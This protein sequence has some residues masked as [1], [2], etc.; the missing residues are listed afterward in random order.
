MAIISFAISF[1]FSGIHWLWGLIVGKDNAF[2]RPFLGGA[3][4]IFLLWFIFSLFKTIRTLIG[5]R[6][7]DKNQPK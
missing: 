3:L 7:L 5:L 4:G 6:H 2:L 1:I